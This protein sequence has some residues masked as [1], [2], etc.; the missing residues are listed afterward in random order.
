MPGGN[1]KLIQSFQLQ[2]PL[3]KYNSIMVSFPN[4]LWIKNS[5]ILLVTLQKY[6]MLQLCCWTF[7]KN[8]E[9]W[10]LSLCG[11]VYFYTTN[12]NRYNFF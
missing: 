12:T 8:N 6:I 7:N 2:I 4:L 11:T 9:N 5:E 1:K 10:F 3:T